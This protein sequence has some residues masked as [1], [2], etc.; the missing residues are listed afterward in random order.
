MCVQANQGRDQRLI[1]SRHLQPGKRVRGY[2]LHFADQRLA[3]GKAT[4]QQSAQDWMQHD[5]AGQTRSRTRRSRPSRDVASQVIAAA[6]RLSR[7]V[8]P[9]RFG[10][11]VAHVY[12]PLSY[13]RG[14]H[15]AFVRLYAGGRKRVV[16]LGMNP[17]PFG[18]TQTGVPF[19]A[20]RPVREWL[21]IEA[22]VGRPKR[23]H[24]KRPVLG[25]E[26]PRNEVSGERLWGAAAACFGTPRRFFA[27][28]YVANYC[29]LLFLEESGRN[30]TPDKLSARE[31]E[32]L[33]AVCDTHLLRLV[34]LFEPAWVVGIGGFAAGRAEA[35]LGD[36]GV[37]VGRILHPSPANPRAQRDWAGSVKREL[38]ELGV[39]R[40]KAGR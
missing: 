23:E 37:R 13:A 3:V 33:F 19:G 34:D 35:V 14:G 20:V 32:R 29:P 36:S 31:R 27:R 5:A 7:E 11:P 40:R 21:G 2:P 28:H 9:L 15:E 6:R 1:P 24:P 10:P 39:W 12:N 17:G 25:F 26:C 18:M 4:P 22:P 38:T 30:L 8:A 16:F